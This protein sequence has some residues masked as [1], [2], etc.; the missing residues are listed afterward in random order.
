MPLGQVTEHNNNNRSHDLCNY[1]INVKI[2]NK[3]LKHDIIQKQVEQTDHKVTEQLHSPFDPGIIEHNILLHKKAIRKG[4]DKGKKQGSNV[5]L[6]C[7][8]PEMQVLLIQY[9]PETHKIEHESQKGI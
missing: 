6:E 3:D 5:C 4:Y 1:R 8:K 7:I 9:I 2:L